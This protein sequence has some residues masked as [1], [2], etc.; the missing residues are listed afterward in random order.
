MENCHFGLSLSQILKE[1]HKGDFDECSFLT[2][3]YSMPRLCYIFNLYPYFYTIQNRNQVHKL[4]SGTQNDFFFFFCNSPFPKTK[5]FPIFEIVQQY[6]SLLVLH[7]NFL[8]L[9]IKCL[10][11]NISKISIYIQT[12]KK[13]SLHPIVQVLI[14]I[15]KVANILLSRI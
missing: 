12:N 9:H 15:S 1:L 8:V 14:L 10:L 11:S 7:T 5:F 4:L 6:F 13:A 3:Q 2:H